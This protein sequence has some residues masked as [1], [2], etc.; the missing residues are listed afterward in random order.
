MRKLFGTDGVR[1]LANQDLTP[2]L[3]LALGRALGVHIK[4][5]ART[6][7]VVIGKDTRLSGYMLETA[8]S[9]GLCSVGVDVWLCGPLPTPGIAFLTQS[10]RA[11]AGVVISASHNPFA[12][13]GIKIFGHDGFKLPDDEEDA[14]EMLMGSEALG[15]IRPSGEGI[16][17]ARRID[18]SVGRYVVY[19]KTLFPKD[20]DLA[21]ITLVVDAGHGAAYRVAPM[22]F[23]E[24]GAK[25][26]SIGDDPSGTNIN[27]SGALH[28]EAMCAAVKKHGA[29]LGIA[30]D[31]DADRVIVAC[32]K[33]ELLDGDHLLAIFAR[34]MLSEKQL[35]GGGVVATV[36]SNLGLEQSLTACGLKLLRAPVGDRYVV[37]EM[38]RGGFNLGGEQSGH[39]VNLDHAT[40]G[41]G[42]VAAL[43]LLQAARRQSQT[44]SELG[45]CMETLPQ[46]LLGIKVKSK[47]PFSELPKVAS[48]IAAAEKALGDNGR[49]LV[50]YSGTENKARVMV[51][52][53]DESRVNQ[54]A[55]DIAN[56]IEAA[57]A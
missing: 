1:G 53:R 25:V 20:L 50:R 28:P 37:E 11:D 29:D 31:G 42:V 12:D 30:L 40:T 48:A 18:D 57:L 7:Q 27:D 49:V 26:I 38:R 36:M 54:F 44:V 5:G 16:G 4:R 34:Q 51:E 39:I 8:L 19:L 35:T 14:L 24:L 56:E 21:G 55:Q 33:G 10:M 23:S 32:E 15:K 52:G 47:P 6:H 41:D 46:V 2:E 17:K 45:R 22:V 13:N 43:M 9:A 3:A